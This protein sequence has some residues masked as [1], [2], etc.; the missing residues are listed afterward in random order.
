MLPKEVP[1][2]LTVNDYQK[3]DG[4]TMGTTVGLVLA[5]IF[6]LLLLQFGTVRYVDG[7]FTMF[8]S[9]D[10][11]LIFYNTL[12]SATIPLMSSSRSK[13]SMKYPL[14]NSF[15]TFP[16]H[17][18]HDIYLPKQ[19]STPNGTPPRSQVQSQLHLHTYLSY[20]VKSN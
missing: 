4:V 19:T 5:R 3:P 20:L 16:Q 9:I 13:K 10:T 17:F 12:T 7:T 18:F 1:L 2:F 8:D 6:V 11:A 14:Q 15:P